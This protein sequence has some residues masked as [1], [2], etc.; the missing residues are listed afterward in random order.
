M[1]RACSGGR[2]GSGPRESFT[3]TWES[4]FLGDSSSDVMV[5]YPVPSEVLDRIADLEVTAEDGSEVQISRFIVAELP[6]RTP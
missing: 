6:Y 2:C 5:L 1:N 3:N 4:R